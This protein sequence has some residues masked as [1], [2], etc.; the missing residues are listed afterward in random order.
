MLK[1]VGKA[2]KVL[3]LSDEYHGKVTPENILINEKGRVYLNDKEI[4]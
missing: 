1:R 3:H 2:L 4:A